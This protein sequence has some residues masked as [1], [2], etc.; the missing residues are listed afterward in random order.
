MAAIHSLGIRPVDRRFVG[1]HARLCELSDKFLPRR[2]SLAVL[3]ASEVSKSKQLSVM[4]TPK[5]RPGIPSFMQLF[6][7][8]FHAGL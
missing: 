5:L 7:N 1:T 4:N 2:I 6:L 8:A 3:P